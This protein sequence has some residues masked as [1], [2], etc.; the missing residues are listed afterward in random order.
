MK[1]FISIATMAL[2]LS[3]AADAHADGVLIGPAALTPAARQALEREIGQARAVDPAAFSLLDALRAEL[4]ALDKNKRGR[5]AS[6][7]PSLKAMG[8][9]A[10]MP[11]LAELAL[12]A[13][14]RGKLTASAWQAWRVSLLEAVGSLRDA[15]SRS[16]LMAIVGSGLDDALLIRAAAGALGKEGSDAAAQKL[17]ALEKSLRGAQRRALI[18]GMGHCRRR[19]V[20]HHLADVMTNTTDPRDAKSLSRALGDVG[21][22]WAWET[23]AVR[24]TGEEHATR[25]AAAEALIDGYVAFDDAELRELFT[26]AVLVVDWQGTKALIQSARQGASSRLQAALDALEQRFDDSPLH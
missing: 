22:A 24:K 16:V 26:Q 10:L 23:P 3:T 11:M 9:R 7:T 19:A 5:L 1:R 8:K 17:I 2:A 20:A 21:S 25:S 13:D 12:D 4:P 15:R 6:V 18:A 14:P